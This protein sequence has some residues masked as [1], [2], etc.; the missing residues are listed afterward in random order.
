MD[1]L[2]SYQHRRLELA[3]MLGSAMDVARSRQ[4]GQLESEARQILARLAEDQFQLAVVGQFSRGKSTLMNA[5]LG[6]AY[7]PT[8]ALPMTSVITTVRYDS[9]PRASV[10]RR[11]SPV[12]IEAPLGEIARFVAQSSME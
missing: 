3:E 6:A 9:R 7:L 4:D 1:G 11:G 8:G 5:V 12:P 10:R 2:R